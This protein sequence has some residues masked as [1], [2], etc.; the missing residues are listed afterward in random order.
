MKKVWTGVESSGKDLHLSIEADLVLQRNKRWIKKRQ[1]QGL[2]FIPRTMAFMAPMSPAFIKE[3]EDSGCKYLKFDNLSDILGLNEVDIFIGE[4]IKLFPANGSNS[5]S[6]EQLDFI[7]QGAKDGVHMYCGSQDF[8][9][10]HK[11]F[12]LLVNE[13]F[14][15]TKI[16]G[17]RRPIKSAPPVKKVWGL[18]MVRS[19]APHSFKGDSAT[20]ESLGW[21][22]WTW[23]R[24]ED[25][26]RFDTSYKVPLTELP[27]K[28]LRPQKEILKNPDGTIEKERVRWV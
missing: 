19:V 8:S 1:K 14:V 9:Q 3:I 21:P 6:R 2:P 15:V 20:M 18:C 16:I 12:R 22:S 25:C 10:V 27:P 23:I 7:T 26:L 4:L 17:S 13:V 24:L 5:L 11:Q 28:Y